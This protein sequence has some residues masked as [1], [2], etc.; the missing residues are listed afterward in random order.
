M[1]VARIACRRLAALR[2]SIPI[3]AVTCLLL[4]LTHRQLRPPANRKRRVLVLLA[5][6][7]DTVHL[8]HCF[9]KRANAGLNPVLDGLGHHGL[10]Q[11]PVFRELHKVRN[12]LARFCDFGVKTVDALFQTEPRLRTAL[13]QNFVERGNLRLE[14]LRQG[15]HSPRER[16]Q[17]TKRRSGRRLD[18]RS[19]LVDAPRAR[20][21]RGYTHSSGRSRRPGCF[22]ASCLKLNGVLAPQSDDSRLHQ[23]A[24]RLLHLGVH[25]LQVH[26][27]KIHDHLF[28]R[29]DVDLQILPPFQPGAHFVPRDVQIFFD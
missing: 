18:A 6:H 15:T 27:L 28:R 12:D 21:S 13:R 4:L 22:T 3:A 5:L 14:V 8:R 26:P 11:I 16:K 25:F 1:V 24:L 20:R 29:R 19:R 10:Q 23:R 9:F 7:D 2:Q 17:R